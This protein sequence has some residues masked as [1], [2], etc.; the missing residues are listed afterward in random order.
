MTRKY[1]RSLPLADVEE[2]DAQEI[3][4][5]ESVRAQLIDAFRN[6]RGETA[7]QYA[8]VLRA[9]AA[10]ALNT[11]ILEKIR[12]E[13]DATRM[14]LLPFLSDQAGAQAVPVFRDLIDPEKP[15]LM[16]AFA[17]TARRVYPDMPI[18]LQQEVFETASIPEVKACAVAGLL[19][20]SL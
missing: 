2:A 5:D 4:G 13:D 3:F 14:A 20:D 12:T 17:R 8:V 15:A 7:I 16:V 18:A 1:V 9:H 19:R 6:S 11:K 10:T